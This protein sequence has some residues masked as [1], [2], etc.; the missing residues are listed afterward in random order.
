MLVDGDW[1]EPGGPKYLSDKGDIPRLY[2]VAALFVSGSLI[3]ICEGEPD[4]WAVDRI[5]GVPAVGVQGATAWNPVFAR[6][7]QG[8]QRVL[9]VKDHDPIDPKTGRR[10]GDA[11]YAAIR[12]DIPDAIAVSLPEG[13]DANSFI[14]QYG[15]EEMRIR[16]GLKGV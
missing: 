13:V 6:M 5:A 9:V 10:P 1:I 15:P 7:L 12:D 8:Y 14:N 2:N 3:A 16:M 11:L 4:T